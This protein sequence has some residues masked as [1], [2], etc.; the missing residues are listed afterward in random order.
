MRSS[1]SSANGP[2][3]SHLVLA[4]QPIKDLATGAT[5]AVEAL[6]RWRN[7]DGSHR[8]PMEFLHEL[9]AF[10]Q[11]LHM[12]RWITRSAVR[13]LIAWRRMG[14]GALRMCINYSIEELADPRLPAL[15]C[16]SAHLGVPPEM[17]EIEVSERGPLLEYPE[18]I[19]TL[20]TL[21]AAGFR[22]ALDDFGAG[23]S[24]LRYLLDLPITTVKFDRSFIMDV[25]E[26]KNAATVLIA[27]V[28]MAQSLGHDVVV[29]GI[30]TVEQLRFACDHG[31]KYGQGFYL[32]T[33][34]AAHELSSRLYPRHAISR[35]LH[36]QHL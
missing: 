31:F 20:R 21:R 16:R 27:S 28:D 17:I 5:V 32:G 15:L 12:T 8:L 3:L 36:T 23:S 13:Q 14:L 7:A 19:S 34:C 11:G 18:A 24:S 6:A 26:S 9:L 25:M 33:P 35:S 2:D 29:E 22:I 4:F 1:S 30:E 10:Q